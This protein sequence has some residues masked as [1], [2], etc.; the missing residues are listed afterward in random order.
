MKKEKV[1]LIS[2]DGLVKQTFST[3]D[4]ISFI[5]DL[6]VINLSISETIKDKFGIDISGYRC[7]VDN[8]AVKHSF[9][10]HGSEKTEEKRN[11]I[12]ISI[13]TILLIPKLLKNPDNI[14]Y[15]G[16]NNI[17]RDVI[18]FEKTIGDKIICV[19]EIRTKQKELAFQTIYIKKAR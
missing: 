4:N 3:K 5:V 15:G 7:I 9:L 14:I 19:E 6:G 13:D 17:G 8:Y 11:Q 1:K 12:P 10:Q 16:K 18:V 2:L